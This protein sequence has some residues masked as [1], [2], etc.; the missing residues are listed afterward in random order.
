MTLS[1][2]GRS[3]GAI[4]V[5]IYLHCE[6]SLLKIS[7]IDTSNPSGFAL[8]GRGLEVR[9][10]HCRLESRVSWHWKG[11]SQWKVLCRRH[12]AHSVSPWTTRT[13]TNHHEDEDDG[14]HS[15][16]DVEHE[17]DVVRQLV[18]VFHI[19]HQDGWEQE[20]QGDAHL[21]VRAPK[22]ERWLWASRCQP[23][24]HV[25]K[26]WGVHRKVW[27]GKGKVEKSFLRRIKF[28]HLTFVWA[29]DICHCVHTS[30]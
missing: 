30:N 10:S 12:N 13:L 18:H 3:F 5:Q 23:L 24:P 27:K 11:L 25:I 14:G 8:R 7:T 6:C 19:G 15:S 29:T 16:A 28:W 21:W 26:E 22:W 17:P 20:A 2:Q 9:L 1:I 4:T